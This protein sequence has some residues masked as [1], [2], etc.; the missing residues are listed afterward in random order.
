M[1]SDLEYEEF[2]ED[3]LRMLDDGVGDVT[4]LL[5]DGEMMAHMII[6]AVRSEY[7]S[8]MRQDP[9]KTKTIDMQHTEMH[10][11]RTIIS[12]LYTGEIDIKK[13]ILE[14]LLKT[15]DVFRKFMLSK[16]F[17]RC[18]NFLTRNIRKRKF[19]VEE[20]ANGFLG[21]PSLKKEIKF[22]GGGAR[23]NFFFK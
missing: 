14:D 1:E 13:M 23:T 3:M 6:L 10:I 16:Q 9:T 15:I 2:K 4:I 11:M 7:F 12:F 21:K 18:V 17:D 20:V 22:G 5:K 19:T 8:R